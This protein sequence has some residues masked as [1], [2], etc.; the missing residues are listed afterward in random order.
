MKKIFRGKV[1]KCK[2]VLHD[3]RGYDLF[4]ASLNSK[5]I[6]ITIGRP[7][8]T[9]S[10]QENRYYW[11]VVIKLLSEL[12]GYTNDEIHDAMRM[13]FLINRDGKVVTLKSTKNLTTI[14][15]EEYMTKIRQWANSELDCYI[16]E[17]NEV[18][19]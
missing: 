6:E 17:P 12:T 14:Q 10:N 1:E 3:Q 8:K 15:F 7:S 5:D 9:R 4:V 16:P 18:E 11:G 2:V 13:K 19:F